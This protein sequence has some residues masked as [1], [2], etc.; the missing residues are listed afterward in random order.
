MDTKEEKDIL[1]GRWLRDERCISHE[2]AV[3]AS[4]TV[5]KYRDEL[6]IPVL[7]TNGHVLFFKFRRAPWGGDGPKYRYQK[8]SS[9]ALYGA[10]TLKDLA[11]GSLVIVCE[12]ELDALAMRTLGYNAVS[13]SGGAG[14]WKPHWGSLLENFETVVLYDADRAGVEGALK[15]AS[16]VPRAR[17]AWLPVEHG[18]DPTD[19]IKA[20]FVEELRAA[21]ED[22]RR[23]YVPTP[24]MDSDD[25]LRLL[26]ELVD[27]FVAERRACMTDPNKTPFHR[28]LALDAI[29]AKITEE[30]EAMWRT[31][32]PAMADEM[33]T[34]IER[35]RAYPIAKMIKVSRDGMA[36]CVYHHEGTPSMKVY[37]DNHAF[38][39]CCDKRSDAIDI[40]MALNNC[41]FKE[42]V[43][44][45]SV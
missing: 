24:E 12:G 33:Q 23:Y 25:R 5:D 35:A 1:W 22:A 16:R 11:P 31:E 8:G 26:M 10:E 7:N 40:F 2:V 38:S 14:T 42:A 39:Y 19:V 29:R 21:V 43:A 41:T 20:G 36:S 9:A 3:A 18:K 17:I 32:R 6:R 30:K 28:D 4:L 37:R 45:L 44:E 15:V 34:S 13:S 27:V